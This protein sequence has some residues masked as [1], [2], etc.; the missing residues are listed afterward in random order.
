M[1]KAD[2]LILGNSQSQHAFRREFVQDFF[3][4]AGLKVYHLGFGYGDGVS[5]AF[6]IIEKFD[7]KPRLIIVNIG[8]DFFNNRYS[9]VAHSTTNHTKLFAIQEVNE[10]IM[11]RAAR[12]FL[13]RVFAYQYIS[14]REKPKDT[15]TKFA[16]LRLDERLPFEEK[17]QF[18]KFESSSILVPATRE[19]LM[20]VNHRSISTGFWSY[21]YEL[22]WK[23]PIVPRSGKK[24]REAAAQKQLKN[25]IE[26][27]REMNKRSSTLILT[28]V[29]NNFSGNQNELRDLGRSLKI[30]VIFPKTGQLYSSDWSHLTKE[31][32]KEF[33]AAFLK[34]LPTTLK[35]H[36]ICFETGCGE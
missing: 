36:G 7:L 29:P 20:K 2:V 6:D 10:K 35:N 22:P 26:F 9:T 15:F 8:G 5:F 23:I 16:P 3:T 30:P 33:S 17:S 34:E 1:R 13:S 27:Q 21:D 18:R 19:L 12:V 32:A 11:S 31:S 28:L 24:R 4:A 14:V 25:A